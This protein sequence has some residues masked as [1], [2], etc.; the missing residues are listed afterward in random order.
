MGLN[1]VGQVLWLVLGRLN[2]VL[3]LGFGCG[4]VPLSSVYKSG[5]IYLHSYV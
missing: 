1:K 2:E 4:D 3:S 5:A